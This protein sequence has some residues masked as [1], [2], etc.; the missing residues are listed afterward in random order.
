[1]L[2]SIG[3]ILNW[4]KTGKIVAGGSGPKQINNPRGIYIDSDDTLY[5]SDSGNNRIQKWTLNATVGETV[6]GASN[7]NRGSTSTTLDGPTDITFDRQGYMYVV[8]SDNHRVQRYAPNSTIGE[9]VAGAGNGNPGSSNDRLWS[10]RSIAV[11]NDLNIYITDFSNRRVMKWA[12]NATSGTVFFSSNTYSQPYGIILKDGSS[13][14]IYVSDR[15][16]DCVNQWFFGADQ[17]NKTIAGVNTGDLSQ[18]YGITLD[19]F[20]NLYVADS[21]KRRV[22]KFCVGSTT[23]IVIVGDSG[24][25]PANIY[26]IDIAFDSNWNLYMSDDYSNAIIKFDRL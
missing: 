4:N 1:M 19:F 18:P 25:S 6:A 26:P 24:T 2:F 10:P 13:N 5:I 23:P 7:G 9:T 22:F 21:G 17:P 16:K 12:P 3:T 14:E 11:D 20:G 8:D 15:A